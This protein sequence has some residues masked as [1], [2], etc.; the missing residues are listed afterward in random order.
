MEKPV[1]Q[2]IENLDPDRIRVWEWHDRQDLD[3][4]SCAAEIQSIQARGQLVPALVRK[5]DGDCDHDFE[6]I[7]GAKRLFAARYLGATLKAEVRDISDREALLAMDAENQHRS[8]ISPYERALSYMRW[9]RQGVFESQEEIADA[10]GVSA[11][12]ISRLL[13]LARLPAVVVAAF[14]KGSLICEAW[15]VQICKALDDQVSREQLI[16]KARRLQSRPTRLPPDAVFRH[17]LDGDLSYVR[18]Q[19]MTQIVR[20]ADN[21][22]VLFRVH[23]HIATVS[24]K[25][26][27]KMVSDELLAEVQQ[28]IARVLQRATPPKS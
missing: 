26:P 3:Q 9:L 8:D 6:L 12:Q 14:G 20:S 21:N 13:S 27:R 10:V 17:L 24:L 4:T 28:T 22:V 25:L 2:V 19:R 23:Y 1:P 18:R 5:I 15:A 16:R 7:Y 11:S